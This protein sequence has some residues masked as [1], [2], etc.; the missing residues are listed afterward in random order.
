MTSRLLGS[1]AAILGLA[2][3]SQAFPQAYPSKPVTMVVPLGPG[4]QADNV[5]RVLAE[6]LQPPSVSPSWWKTARAPMVRSGPSTSRRQ[7]RT[8]IRCSL[9][10]QVP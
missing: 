1:A 10:C 4:S 7:H 5:A 8:D 2:V 3:W 6:R 9:H